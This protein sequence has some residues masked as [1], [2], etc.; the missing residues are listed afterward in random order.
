M[1]EV[2]LR[3][4][5]V[6]KTF[7]GPK[8][9]SVT[10][11]N[12]MSLEIASGEFVAMGGS[13]GC[14]KSTILLIAGG[15]LRPDQGELEIMGTRP[16]EVDSTRRASIRSQYIGFVF[17]QFH[18]V[19]YLD[20]LDNVLAPT[21]ARSL[22][23]AE[24][25]AMALLEKFGLTERRHHV[26]SALSVGEQQRVALARALLLEPKLLLADEPTGNLD[27]ENTDSILD[28]LVAFAKEGGA[29]LM[30]THDDLAA[31]RASRS[32]RM[33]K[34]SIVESVS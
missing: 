1:S 34:G 25:K 27:P 8:G 31:N 18:L 6:Q 14:G 4:T 26:P 23:D 7:A 10:A 3:A 16:Y 2:T 20:A 21:L 15:L 19:P 24:D 17:Q 13:S 33:E 22:P 28:H 5:N 32:I 29:V 11:V 9:S 12:D 30:V